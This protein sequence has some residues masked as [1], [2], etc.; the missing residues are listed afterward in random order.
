MGGGTWG[1]TVPLFGAVNGMTKKYIK[2]IGALGGRQLATTHTT[3]NQKQ[4]AATKGNME[5]RCDEREVRR[6]RNAIV[7]GHYKLIGGKKLK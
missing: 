2:Y 7:W 3:T 5:G 4:M 6:K 1:D